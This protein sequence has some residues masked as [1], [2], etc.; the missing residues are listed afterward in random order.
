VVVSDRDAPDGLSAIVPELKY[1]VNASLSMAAEQAGFAVKTVSTASDIGGDSGGSGSQPDDGEGDEPE[2]PSPAPEK[3][4]IQVSGVK[5]ETK[6]E[7][8]GENGRQTYA[9]QNELW[10]RLRFALNK[11]F[12]KLRVGV[13]F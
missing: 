3:T 10:L 13:V 7:E 5:E 2:P 9:E 11:G 4:E 6:A 12:D 8:R 1:L